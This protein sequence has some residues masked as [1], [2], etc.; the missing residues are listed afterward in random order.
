[1][2]RAAQVSTS[3]RSAAYDKGIDVATQAEQM[4][5]GNSLTANSQF[6]GDDATKLGA[7]NLKLDAQTAGL[8]GVL[9]AGNLQQGGFSLGLDASQTAQGANSQVGQAGMNADA[10][11]SS[12]LDRNTQQQSNA[13]AGY[14]SAQ[15]AFADSLAA[16]TAFQTQEQNEIAGQLQKMGLQLDFIQQYMASI[17]GNF[18]SNGFETQVSQ[19]P[20]LLQQ[21]AGLAATYAGA[22]GSFC[23]VAREVYGEDNPK[24]KEFRFWMFDE[25]NPWFFYPYTKYGENLAD[26][27]YNNP[28]LKRTVRRVFD[29][30]LDRRS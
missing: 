16:G 29:W 12:A 25:A 14:D 20:G 22:G 23:W 18:G 19:K 28:L 21:A 15:K 11:V 30:I 4:R 27:I 9:N 24:W 13:T 2:D 17:G 8:S 7:V 1:M 3:L 5:Q 6:Q 10:Q 26:L